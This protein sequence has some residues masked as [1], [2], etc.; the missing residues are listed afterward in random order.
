MPVFLIQK[1]KKKKKTL[2]KGNWKGKKYNDFLFCMTKHSFP[3]EAKNQVE[4]SLLEVTETAWRWQRG[5]HNSE[6]CSN[7]SKNCFVYKGVVE[8]KF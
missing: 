2:Q 7:T 1:K 5:K 6:L 8:T 3:L 4:Y